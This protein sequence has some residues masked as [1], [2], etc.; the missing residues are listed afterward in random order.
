[1][2]KLTNSV[3]VVVLSSSFVFVNAQKKQ[4]SAKTKDIEGV[5]VTA[6]GIKR[7]KKSLGYA[8]QEVKADKLFDGTTNTGNIASQLSGK[9]SGLQVNTSSN[10]G[11]S[12]SLV[13]RGIKSLQGANPLIVIDG[14]P[15]NNSSTYDT[16][17]NQDMGNL[18]SDINQDDIES[19]NVLKGAAASALY[20]ERGL[21]G[22]I[23]I[24]TKSGKGK[25]DGSWGVTLSSSVQAGFIDKSTFP[26][27]QNRYGAGY[28]MSFSEKN[29]NGTPYGNL[30]D[31]A[32]WGPEFNPN[33]LVYQWDAFDPNSKNFGKATP[34][35]AAKNGPIKFFETPIT[36]VN[37][38]TLEKGK[39]GNNFMLS[40]DNMLSNGLLP[41]SDLRKNTFTTKINYDFTPKLHATVYSTLVVQ[42][43]KGRNDANYSGNLVGG[44]RQWW[45]NNVDIVDQKNAYFNSGGKNISWNLKSGANPVVGFWNN[46]YYQR[47]QS[48]SSDDRTRSFSYASLTYDFNKNFS[49]IGKVSYDNASTYFQNRLAPGSVP[50]AFGASQKLVSSGYSRQNLTT[51]ETNFDLMLNY[52]FNITDNINVSGIAGGNVRRNY[53]NSIY[54]STEGGLEKDGLYALANSKFPIIPPDENEYTTVTSSAYATASFDFYKFFYLDATFRADKTSTLPKANRVYTYP[55][56]TGSFI[57]SEFVKPSWLSFW[58]VRA[59]YAEVG[60]TADPYQLQYYYTFAGTFNNSIVMQNSQTLLANPDL[61]PQRSK[62]FE[63]GTEAHFFKGRL[64]F[65]AAYYKTKTFNQIINLPISAGSGLLTAVAN[66]GRID[67]EGIELQI[68][69][70]PIKT[71]D[72][73]WNIDVNWSKNKNKVV[74]LLH[75]ATTDVSNYNLTSVQGGAS[76]N[77]TEGEMWGAIRGSDYKYLNGQKVVDSKGFYVLEGNK[78]IGNTTPDWIGGVRNSFSYKG[79][80]VSFLV[81][82]RKGGDIFSTDMYYATSTGLYKDTAIGDYRTGKVV[83]PGVTADGQ[84]NQTAIDASVYGNMGYQKSPTS[85]YVYDGS[86]IKLREASISYTLPKALLANTFVNEA[87]ISIVGRNLW[88]I[89]KNLPYADPESTLGGGVRSFGYSIGSLPTTRDIGVNISFKF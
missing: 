56:F 88:I 66:A 26:E 6:L 53:Y 9:V 44:F 72:F 32:S 36:Y 80:S 51:T 42:N 87:K 38:I 25:D 28:A 59:N 81:D 17:T 62:E 75:N 27:Y 50:K 16:K 12:S 31:D 57:L 5:V 21:N 46:P 83:L 29:T 7:E 89:H 18:L 33:Q 54:A 55:S 11:G 2:K 24:T 70:T 30:G 37:G 34:W 58:K 71:K 20:G 47:Y 73:S 10:F 1:M 78:V 68:G 40:Y 60:G 45:A 63:V 35:V 43:T 4:D 74:E 14:S 82:F 69:A 77:A 3:L 65:D 23:V 19:I 79:I 15:V 48:Y 85:R 86:F 8:S 41:N 61:K 13:I 67:N 76:V 49:L 64:T 39:K 52:K 84:P 22:V